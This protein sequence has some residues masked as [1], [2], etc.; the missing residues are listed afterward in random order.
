M[1]DEDFAEVDVLLCLLVAQIA[2]HQQRRDGGDA[3][4][5]SLSAVQTLSQRL[6]HLGAAAVE[7][8]WH[9]SASEV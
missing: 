6:G 4:W 7:R 9:T 5:V 2:H 8:G 1:D 3:D